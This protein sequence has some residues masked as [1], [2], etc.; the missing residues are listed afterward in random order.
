MQTQWVCFFMRRLDIIIPVKNEAANLPDLVR[1]IHVCLKKANIAYRLVV[2]DDYSTDAI[3]EVVKKLAKDYPIIT[4]LKAGKPGKAYSILEGAEKTSS[5]YVAIIDPE[6]EYPPE[7]IPEMYAKVA[8]HG[9]VVASRRPAPRLGRWLSGKLLL[10]LDCD[11]QSGIMVFH[12]HILAHIR[13]SGAD[14]RTLGIPLLHTALE[15][16]CTIGQVDVDL[17]TRPYRASKVRFPAAWRQIAGQAV[18]LHLTHRK[19]YEIPAESESCPLGAGVIHHRHRFITH[20]RLPQHQSAMDTFLPWQKH[21]LMALLALTVVAFMVRPFTAASWTVAILTVVYFLDVFFNGFIIAK[22]LR[23]P[24]EMSF[25]PE[26]LENLSPGGLPVYSVL[27]PLYREA[28]VLPEFVKNIEAIDWPK[29][30]MDVLLLL[31]E[32]DKETRQAAASLNLPDYIKVVVVPHSLPKTKPKACNYGLSYVRGEY[33]VIYDAEDRPDPLQLKKAYLGF[34]KSSPKVVCLQAKLNYY[35][36]KHNL[37]T[38]LF[39]A[40]YTLWFDVVLPGLQ[41]IE[42]TIPLG[43]TSNHFRTKVLKEIHGWDAFNVTEDCDLGV[44]LFSMG[45]RT[46]IIDSTTYE[47]ANSRIGSWFRQRSRW[48]KGYLQTFLVH[49]RHPLRFVRTHGVHAFIFQLLVG[50]KNA[51]VLIN[52]ILWLITISYFLFRRTLGPTIEALYPPVIFY[53]AVFSMLAGNFLSMYYY[54]LGCARRGTWWL[55]K[56]V[57][58]VPFYWFL[59]SLAAV[60]AVNQLLFKPHYWEK[61]MHGL[62]LTPAVRFS[63]PHI[64]RIL[65]RPFPKPAYAAG[66][67]LVA[68]NMLAN[69]FNFLYNAFLGRAVGLADFGLISLFGSIL[70][71]LQISTGALGRTVSYQSA[72]L[73]GKHHQP[74]TVFWQIV[75]RRSFVIS[76]AATLFWLLATPFLTGFFNS[77]STMPFYMFTPIVTLSALNA[78]DG[79]F[80]SGNLKFA[81]LALAGIAAGAVKL[82]TAYISVTFSVSDLVYLAIPASV[83]F[84]FLVMRRAAINLP[85]GDIRTG[86]FPMHFLTT[87]FISNLSMASFLGADLI[88]AKH[89]LDP[90]AA[91]QYAI[92][93]LAGKMVYFLGSLFNQFIT[94]LVAQARGANSNHSRLFYFLLAAAF[95]SGLAG[96]LVVGIFGHITVP[97]FFGVKSLPILEFLPAYTLSMVLLAV[98]TAIASYH[99]TLKQYAF[100]WAG[101]AVSVIQI[102][103]FGLYHNSIPSFVGV[104]QGTVVLY[105]AINII[106]HFLS[107][108]FDII[109]RNLADLRELLFPV[110]KMAGES[111]GLRILIFNWRDI[112]HKWA[113]GAEVYVHELAKNWVKK[114]NQVTLFCGND[115]HCPRREVTDGVEIIRRG[116]T[117][118]VYV[119]AFLYYIFRFRNHFDAIVD[120]ENGIPFFAPLYTRVPTFLLVHHVHQNYFQRYLKSPLSDIARIL[121]ADVMPRIYRD[122][123]VVT[124]S[125]SSKKDLLNFKSFREENITVVNPGVSP[126]LTPSYPK[127]SQPSFLYLGR[128]RPYK[129]IDV[130]IRAFSLVVKKY[131]QAT[132]T[133]AGTGENQG[134]LAALSRTLGISDRVSF[135]GRVNEVSKHRLLS[136]SWVMLQPSSFEGW[137]ITVLEANA[138]GTPVIASDTEG[139]RDSVVDTKTGWLL[140]V[141][142]VVTWA[143][144]MKSMIEYPTNLERLSANAVKWSKSFDWDKNAEQFFDRIYSDLADRKVTSGFPEYAYAENH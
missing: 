70:S 14:S 7:A 99:Q 6:S 13:L 47:E 60:K 91:G 50:G 19:A 86:K 30:K 42:T 102:S 41:S 134:E 1:R 5:E 127:T 36:P 116:G 98:G 88:L 64:S 126:D 51:F 65:P 94:P 53:M 140:P 66:S 104:V 143:S 85:K 135:T 48:I 69:V 20:T 90:A 31:E 80:L 21:L 137:G 105:L 35:N 45:F 4:L 15:L 130:A 113:G 12:R 58:L 111:G 52:P 8:E 106:L 38:R 132:L 44:R 9:I 136:E 107:P 62:H 46:A 108:R 68:S 101:L 71:L 125:E 73:Q 144:A 114:G 67:F 96:Y 32:D 39:T 117:Y 28:R 118:M 16:G 76:M 40:E 82:A 72:F 122:L 95:F 56:Y 34:K 121:E 103:A 128:I 43:G 18:K 100:S 27:C 84:S 10:G 77:A 129:N 97:L 11:I 37:L 109:S 25:S 141:R 74:A 57:Y 26:Q 61:T 49:N 119:W 75:R 123:P 92:L 55:V 120:S 22:S 89:F 138:C 29:D 81:A 142:D 131:P 24:P 79:G 139:L 54:M 17:K 59:M 112:R 33:T 133:I 3:P 87:A 63:F 124:V 23:H 83:L 2:A 110:R 93:S 78:V 115:G